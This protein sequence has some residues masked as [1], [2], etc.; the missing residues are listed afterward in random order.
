ME[1]TFCGHSGWR[2]RFQVGMECSEKA[3]ARSHLI[4]SV[5]DLS[6]PEVLSCNPFIHSFIHLSIQ[7][8]TKTCCI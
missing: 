1:L 5:M 6:F 2:K 7:S 4:P 8:L 3:S